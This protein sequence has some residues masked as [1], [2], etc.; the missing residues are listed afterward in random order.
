MAGNRV[1]RFHEGVP[2]VTVI[3]DGGWSKR[4]HKHSYNAKPGVAIITGKETGKL[5]HIGI[6]NKFCAACTQGIPKENHSCFKNRSASSSEME[7][8]ILLEGFMQAEQ[9]HGV[10]YTRFDGDGDSSVHTT[11]LQGVPG[12]GHVIKKLECANHACKCYRAGLEKLVQMN[13]SYKGNGG[14]TEKM[15]RKL[16]SAARCAIRM[17]SKEPDQGRRKPLKSGQANQVKV[18]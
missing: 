4:S 6:R 1:R 8:D 14:L 12:R 17:R 10:R 15:R 13:S 16:V 11:L 2:S 18:F 3:V 9:V 5:L 7:S